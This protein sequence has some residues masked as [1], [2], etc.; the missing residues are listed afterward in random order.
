MFKATVEEDNDDLYEPSDD[1]K[2]T[3]LDGKNYDNRFVTVNTVDDMTAEL[4]RE[5]FDLRWNYR[6]QHDYIDLESLRPV[7]EIISLD[8]N[9]VLSELAITFK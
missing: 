5:G 8:V 9:D 2:T 6:S 3:K 1:F 4:Q 7:L